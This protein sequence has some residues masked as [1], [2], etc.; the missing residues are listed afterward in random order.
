MLTQLLCR[1]QDVYGEPEPNHHPSLTV[2]ELLDAERYWIGL[3]QQ[4]QL[5]TEIKLLQAK[6]GV[7]KDYYPSLLC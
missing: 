2:H 4:Q 5:W 6:Q 7:S 1:A 3:S